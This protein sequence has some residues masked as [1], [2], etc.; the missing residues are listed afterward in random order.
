MTA[1][2][3]NSISS[4]HS[5]DDAGHHSGNRNEG[6]AGHGR[7]ATN[8]STGESGSS[9]VNISYQAVLRLRA[10]QEHKEAPINQSLEQYETESG[11]N[12]NIGAA[13]DKMEPSQNYSVTEKPI[14]GDSVA[15]NVESHAA[16]SQ[17]INET[18]FPPF[19]DNMLL[20]VQDNIVQPNEPGYQ[21]LLNLLNNYGDTI[22]DQQQLQEVMRKEQF[23][24]GRRKPFMDSSDFHSYSQVL[25]QF[26]NIVERQQY[27]S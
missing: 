7:Q 8:N 13:N 1:I 20:E 2:H 27:S 18:G 6:G 3:Q 23:F 9:T 15:L 26:A 16:I 22:A 21:H 4:H 24:L 14:L 10:F 11:V 19:I 5:I 12:N 17:K 25:N